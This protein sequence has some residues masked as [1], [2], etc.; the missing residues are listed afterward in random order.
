MN[1]KLAY[2]TL[3]GLASRYVVIHLEGKATHHRKVKEG[4]IGD[5]VSP[6]GSQQC[7]ITRLMI[8]RLASTLQV[9]WK[10]VNSIVFCR[11]FDG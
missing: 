11:T 2:K 4:K 9:F 3:D 5:A 1:K 7:G 10:I 6:I 8:T